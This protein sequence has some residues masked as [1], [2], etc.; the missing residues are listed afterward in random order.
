MAIAEQGLLCALADRAATLE[1][2]L[3]RHLGFDLLARFE[4]LLDDGNV[5]HS[6][7]NDLLDQMECIIVDLESEV[8]S[9][10]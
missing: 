5:N 10:A 8:L 4:A 1:R 2:L 6:E 7:A 3:E 9:I